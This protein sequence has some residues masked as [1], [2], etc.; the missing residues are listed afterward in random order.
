MIEMVKLAPTITLDDYAAVA[1][2]AGA[3]HELRS[4]AEAVLPRFKG[5]SVLMLNSTAQGGGVAEMMPRMVLLANELGVTTHWAVMGTERLEF[6]KL[7]KRLHNLIHGQGDGE[8][9]L[10]DED[11]KLYEEVSLGIAEQLRP[12]LKPGDV[13]IVHDPQPLAVGALLK[14]ELAIHA[15]WRCHIGLDEDL[16]ATRA[17]WSFLRRYTE[18]YDHAVFSAPEY[19]PKFLAGRSSIILPGLDPLSHKNRSL[20]PHKLTGI[21]CNAGLAP[22]HAPVLTPPFSQ[23]ARR[24]QP[25]GEF[26]PATLPDEIGFL[27]RPI[28][29]Q[30]SRWDRLKGFG[31]LLAGFVRLKQRLHAPGA[32]LDARQRRRLEIVRLV[33]AG[34]DPNS[35]QDDPEG[36][37]VLEQLCR[38]YRALDSQVQKDIALLTLPMDSRKNNELIVNAIQRCASIVV[39]NSLR[40]GFGLTVTEAMWKGTP[41][42]GTEACGLRQQIRDGIDGRLVRNPEDPKEIADLLDEMLSDPLERDRWS[43]NAQKRVFTEFLVF[44]Q[45]QH[46]LRVL[47]ECLARGGRA[48]G[49]GHVDA[50][51]PLS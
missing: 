42:L 24:L 29:A 13:L 23:P 40:E 51:L 8:L 47:A 35:V 16:P 3:V 48:E 32:S 25:N 39:Q 30:I 50:V 33:L 7:T 38:A 37:E 31:P 4:E 22:E 6:F 2:L 17:A 10:S 27:Y 28:V 21:L 41:V 49:S 1:Y 45:M 14:R 34:P 15:V 11:R 36:R 18:A 26:G 5:R 44:A 46:W 19:I 12:H 20:T 9:A 43:R